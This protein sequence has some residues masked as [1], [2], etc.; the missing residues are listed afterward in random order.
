MQFLVIADVPPGGNRPD[1]FGALLKHEVE[2]TVQG[3]LDGTLRQ[4]WLQQPGE[5]AVALMEAGSVE[6]AR[7]IIAGW[8]LQRV[9]LLNARLIGQKPFPGFRRD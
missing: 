9:G 6:E 2:S 3:Y 1:N 7:R 4:V 5:G 8:P